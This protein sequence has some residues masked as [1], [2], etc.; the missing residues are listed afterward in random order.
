M[1]YKLTVTAKN[2]TSSIRKM[3]MI[4]T[5]G[6]MDKACNKAEQLF[7]SEYAQEIDNGFKVVNFYFG[8]IKDL[9]AS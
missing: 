5:F 2:G 3:Y 6:G 7:N 8:D 9:S 4:D 1:N